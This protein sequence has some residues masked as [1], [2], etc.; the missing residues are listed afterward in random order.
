[1]KKWHTLS[2]VKM[3]SR[4]GLTELPWIILGGIIHEVEP[5]GVSAEIKGQ[6]F[7]SWLWDSPLDI[8]ANLFG[9]AGGCCYLGARIRNT[10]AS[11]GT[12]SLV[13]PILGAPPSARLTHPANFWS[14][15]ETDQ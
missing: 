10:R 9:V 4:A 3:A 13:P 15:A 14:P 1:M 11:S 6:G 7:F 12:S 8:V 2:N 5:G